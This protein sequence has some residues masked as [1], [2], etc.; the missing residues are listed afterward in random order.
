MRTN[1]FAPLHQQH[2]QEREPPKRHRGSG[3]QRLAAGWKAAPLLCFA[4]LP[5]CWLPAGTCRSGVVREE[6][7]KGEQVRVYGATVGGNSAPLER[8]TK[9][10]RLI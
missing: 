2:R 4:L 8:Q 6:E 10:I 7:K 5:T 3:R 1:L 9:V